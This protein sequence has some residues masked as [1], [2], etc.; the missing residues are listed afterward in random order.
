MAKHHSSGFCGFD[1]HEDH[2]DDYNYDHTNTNNL[3][4]A[5][6]LE[7][8]QKQQLESMK[9]SNATTISNNNNSYSYSSGVMV[10]LLPLHRAC[11]LSAPLHLIQTLVTIFPEACKLKDHRNDWLPLHYCAA[12][13]TYTHTS[14]SS[15]CDDNDSNNNNNNNNNNDFSMN[16]LNYILGQHTNAAKQKESL[17]RLP[18]H[19]ACENGASKSSLQSLLSAYPDSVRCK[20]KDGQLPLH[21]ACRSTYIRIH[22][23]PHQHRSNGNG[24]VEED[25]DVEAFRVLLQACTATATVSDATD[26]DVV[27]M[28][29]YSGKS[30]LDYME[31]N[32]HPN[33]RAI[34]KLLKKKKKPPPPVTASAA[35]WAVSPMI[36]PSTGTNLNVNAPAG[37]NTNTINP[38][39]NPNPAETTSQSELYSAVLRQDWD[40]AISLAARRPS[41][42]KVWYTMRDSDSTAWYRAL[43]IHEACKLNPSFECIKALL[44]AYNAAY[45]VDYPNKCLPL[46]HVCEHGVSDV[47]VTKLLLKLNKGGTRCVDHH[48][49]LPLHLV[50]WGGGR[51]EQQQQQQQVGNGD[52]EVVDLLL[53]IHGPAIRVRDRRGRTPVQI[54]QRRNNVRVLNLLVNFMYQSQNNSNNNAQQHYNS[55]PASPNPAPSFSTLGTF[56]FASK[57]TLTSTMSKMSKLSIMSVKTE[58]YRAVSEKR[59]MDVIRII[60]IDQHPE[61]AN[62]WKLVQ[63]H[64]GS[65]LSRLLPIHLACQINPPDEVIA[66]LLEASPQYVFIVSCVCFF[67][68]TIFL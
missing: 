15:C 26:V 9:K 3:P 51:K 38:N 43:P 60:K 11:E 23:R 41:D 6:P 45:E 20:D 34:L 54:A 13:Y 14:S 63:G 19:L 8:E 57:S 42:A 66:A 48:G 46:H 65:I 58:L 56:S 30:C 24:V 37:T 33:K 25:A 28:K 22:Q 44:L 21:C 53:R 49:M 10:R 7:Q 29:D 1:S 47:R 18:I 31:E 4:P 16:I 39:I 36:P 67:L 52:D 17:G 40:R 68:K 2:D 59:W 5:A 64:D 55:N 12:T 32:P 61:Q 62:E 27:R 50:A 35:H